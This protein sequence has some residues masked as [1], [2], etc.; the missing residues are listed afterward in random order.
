MNPEL[1]PDCQWIGDSLINPFQSKELSG[2]TA[3]SEQD[4]FVEEVNSLTVLLQKA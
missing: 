1:L 4:C 2:A 3:A